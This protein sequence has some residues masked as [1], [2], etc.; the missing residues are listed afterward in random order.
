MS[1][2]SDS[3]RSS[4][5]AWVFGGHSTLLFRNQAW[6][7]SRM[8]FMAAT[9]IRPSLGLYSRFSSFPT[10]SQTGAE[11]A[12]H[13]NHFEKNWIRVRGACIQIRVDRENNE[14]NN[15]FPLGKH[16]F[17]N[18]V[19]LCGIL[20]RF[21]SHTNQLIWTLFNLGANS[22]CRGWKVWGRTRYKIGANSIGGESG[23]FQSTLRLKIQFTW[24]K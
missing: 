10:W 8:V 4:L 20:P 14:K 12:S 15:M 5:P 16:L 19:E 22:T 24:Q 6:L 7:A 2:E 18:S 11:P 17:Y 3:P 21:A 1:N 9:R 13:R 23:E